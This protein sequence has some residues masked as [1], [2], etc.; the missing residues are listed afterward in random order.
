M[1]RLGGMLAGSLLVLSSLHVGAAAESGKT[2][3]MYGGDAA[4]TR[5]SPLSQ[6]NRSNVA[7]LKVAWV[8]QLGSL[9]AQE[10]TP[11]VVGD[12]LFVTTSAG[13]RYVYALNAKDGTLT[14]CR[15]G[16]V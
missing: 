15:R 2:W 6:I 16:A 12:T 3:M 14:V 4:N 9:E 10:S 11:L 8:A 13:P 1:S 7:R 5:F